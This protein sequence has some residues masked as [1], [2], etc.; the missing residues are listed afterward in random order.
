MAIPAN[1]PWA[2]VGNAALHLSARALLEEMGDAF[3]R[4]SWQGSLTDLPLASQKN[5]GR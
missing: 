5:G 3:Y 4:E 2:P 1:L